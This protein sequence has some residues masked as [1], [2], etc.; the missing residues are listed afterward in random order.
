MNEE[1]N[2]SYS[3]LLFIFSHLYDE[4]LFKHDG[5][6]FRVRFTHDSL[7]LDPRRP[8]HHCTG[9]VYWE[10]VTWPQTS[11]FIKQETLATESLV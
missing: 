11:H 7:A 5:L 10:E 1:Y 3:T 6:W 8:R 2:G 9:E 4:F